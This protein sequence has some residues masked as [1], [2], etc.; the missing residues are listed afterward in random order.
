MPLVTCPTPTTRLLVLTLAATLTA[1]GGGGGTTFVPV[2]GAPAAAPAPASEPQ[3]A[4][5]KTL[6]NRADMVSGGD[7]LMEVVLRPP[8]TEVTGL[9]VQLNNKDVSSQFALRSDGRIT[10]LVSGLNIGKNSVTAKVNNGVQ[11]QLDVT[12]YPNGGPIFSGPHLQPWICETE[13]SGLGVSIDADCNV[14]SARVDYFYKSTSSAQTELVPYNAAEPPSDVAQTTLDNGRTVPFIVRREV[15]TSNRGVYAFAVIAS[16]SEAVSPFKSPGAWNGGVWHVLAGGGLPQHRQGPVFAPGEEYYSD[17]SVMVLNAAPELSKGF[18]TAATTLTVFGQNSNSVVSAESLMMLKE[19][20]AEK[21]GE[22]QFTLSTGGSGG[23]LQQNLIANS[24]PGLLDG[25]LPT[26][27]FPDLWSTNTEV[28]DCSLLIRYFDKPGPSLWSDVTKQNAVMDNA[29][30]SPGS[31]RAFV[32]GYRM[33]QGWGD[34]AS[35]SCLHTYLIYTEAPVQQPWMYTSANPT[36]TR[37]TIQDYQKNIFGLRNDG[38]ANRAYDNV[39]VQ[40]GLKAFKV[41]AISIEQ[42][43]DLNKNVGGRDINWGWTAQRTQ[44]DAQALTALYRTGQLNLMDNTASTPIVDDKSCGNSELHS[45]FHSYK[46]R[47]RLRESTGSIANHVLL[48]DKPSSD[49][50]A[51]DMLVAWVRGIKSDK[52][53][54]SIATKVI[55]N[56]PQAAEDACWINGTRVTDIA[57][58]AAAKPYFGDPRTGAGSPISV[59]ASKCQ[60]MP[61]ARQSYGVAMTDSQWT[62]LQSLFPEGVCDY[63]LPGVGASKSVPWLSF[64]KGPGGVPIGAAPV[65]QLN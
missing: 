65:A 64:A 39:G 61:L 26:Q 53:A 58:C 55:K 2:A 41:G 14:T 27:T 33:D 17:P 7:V 24:Y 44:A 29:N 50:S 23:S 54:E 56:K 42:F 6:S 18:V 13:K 12:N 49:Q 48:L 21:I 3:V 57:S 47:E 28:Q 60:L 62:D 15:G 52:S 9:K 19:R 22:I 5:I 59:S 45:C 10:G 51:F 8:V 38:F 63:S 36:G 16:P 46:L 1:C 43:I 32:E 37:C 4:D 31:C 35:T 40:Y 20:I 11:L 30:E 34:P 25:I